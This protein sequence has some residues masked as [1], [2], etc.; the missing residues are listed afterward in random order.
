MLIEAVYFGLTGKTIRKSTDDALVN[1]QE[2][3]KCQV[4]LFLDDGVKIFRQKKPTKL[5]LFVGDEEKTQHTVF[6]TQ[7][8][9]DER[10]KN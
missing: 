1:N 2:K 9:I 8:L 4:E 5:K 7:K 6:D 3:K 10:Y